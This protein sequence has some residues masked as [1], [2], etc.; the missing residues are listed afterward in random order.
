MTVY[1]STRSF[2][3]LSVVFKLICLAVFQGLQGARGP[4]G[5]PG[6]IGIQVRQF[7][8]N[9]VLHVCSVL[10]SLI[11]HSG[12][13][14]S[15]WFPLDHLSEVKWLPQCLLCRT[16]TYF[17]PV[18]AAISWGMFRWVRPWFIIGSLR[19]QS[20]KFFRRNLWRVYDT[21]MPTPV[22]MELV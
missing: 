18:V 13:Y 4:Q 10:N 8:T 14:G 3:T 15:S 12:K 19:K 22:N 2:T 20:W 1:L 16:Y 5:P 6:P 11:K 21:Y 17:I 7:N 9:M